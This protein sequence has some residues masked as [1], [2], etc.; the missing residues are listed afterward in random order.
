MNKTQCKSV[1][2]TRTNGFTLIELLV[3]IAIIA[4]LAAILFPVFARARENAR[5]ASCQSN[6]KQISLGMVQY[7]QD[8]DEKYPSAYSTRP[9]Q[10]P[11]GTQSA[12][13]V[14]W[15][16]MI[17]PYMKSVQI[18]QCPSEPNK[19]NL[20]PDGAGGHDFGW[21]DYFIN[22]NL[23]VY[24][25]SGPSC[26]APGIKIS[27]VPNTSVVIMLGDSGQGRD[28]TQANC[29]DYSS[30]GGG[31]PDMGVN[32]P[33]GWDCTKDG[34][35]GYTA[36]GYIGDAADWNAMNPGAMKRHL[37]GANYAFSDGH[38]KWLKPDM[39]SYNDPATSSKAT[40]RI[41]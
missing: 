21:S 23:A 16:Y 39:L 2:R 28:Y 30:C 11:T 1:Q 8:Y 3:V 41:N 34:V 25:C 40:F 37:E 36:A 14:G 9:F 38:V 5:R 13:A 10:D 6:L 12:F 17:M 33:P 32:I 19:Q 4:L 26:S 29:Y 20:V 31:N 7:T 24:T 27:T 18:M 22:G 15:G 35:V